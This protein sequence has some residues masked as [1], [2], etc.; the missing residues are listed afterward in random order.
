MI[1]FNAIKGNYLPPFKFEVIREEEVSVSSTQ[2]CGGTW[3]WY[4]SSPSGK[5][6]AQS[7]CYQREEDCQTA[8]RHVLRHA[9]D[10]EVAVTK[11]VQHNEAG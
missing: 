7:R 4:L 2:F 8:L 1:D 5:I 11:G 6:L 9:V 3:S 10:A